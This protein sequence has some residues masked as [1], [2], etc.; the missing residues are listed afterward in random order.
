MTIFATNRLMRNI[1]QIEELILEVKKIKPN[2]ND[3]Q[4]LSLV[5][6]VLNMDELD[7]N[8]S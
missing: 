7:S 5:L 8:V 3:D 6:L 2:F 4:A 1:I